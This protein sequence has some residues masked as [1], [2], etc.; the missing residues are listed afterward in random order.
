MADGYIGQMMEPVTF[1]DTAVES[2]DTCVGSHRNPR[3]AAQLHNLRSDLDQDELEA[4]NRALEAKYR[5]VERTEVRV[6]HY[7]T[8]DAEIVLVG[9]GIVARILKGGH[10]AGAGGRD[11]RGSAAAHYAYPFP[12]S[13]LQRLARQA[14]KFLVVE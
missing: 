11:A 2:E 6:E 14:R 10:H 7:R 9:Y 13:H 5:E 1:P 12:I 8:A 4:H 3:D